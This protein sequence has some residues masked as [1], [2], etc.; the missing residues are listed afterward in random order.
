[1]ALNKTILLKLAEKTSK[2]KEL[3]AFLSDIL[4]LESTPKTGWY[5][6][7]YSELLEKH[8]GEEER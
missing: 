7:K 2:D 6:K 3:Q 4:Q 1:M 5:D 8:C